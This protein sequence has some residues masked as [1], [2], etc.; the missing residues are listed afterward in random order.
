[1]QLTETFYFKNYQIS[2]CCYKIASVYMGEIQLKLSS[3]SGSGSCVDLHFHMVNHSEHDEVVVTPCVVNHSEHG[4]VGATCYSYDHVEVI[5]C[6]DGETFSPRGS[7]SCGHN[8]D[9]YGVEDWGCDGV[10]FP[11]LLSLRASDILEQN[12]QLP[13]I[14]NTCPHHLHHH[15]HARVHAHRLHHGLHFHL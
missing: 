8:W 7:G 9:S 4:E 6:D 15:D 13:H 2:I 12:D 5:C 10:R 11:C 1:M 14:H 3:C